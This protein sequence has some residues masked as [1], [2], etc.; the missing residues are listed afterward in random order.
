[1]DAL[2][3]LELQRNLAFSEPTR[4]ELH[5]YPW[6]QGVHK[7]GLE[8]HCLCLRRRCFFFFSFG[9]VADISLRERFC[10]EKVG[11]EDRSVSIFWWESDS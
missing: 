4:Y 3:G 5:Q 11:E 8:C 2:W 7:A 6:W 10:S 9:G 1:M